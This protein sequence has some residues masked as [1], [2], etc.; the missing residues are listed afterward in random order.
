MRSLASW[1]VLGVLG[2]SSCGGNSSSSEGSNGGSNGNDEGTALCREGCEAVL[3]A[4]CENGPATQDS[5]ESDC[6]RLARGGCAEQYQELQG[7]SEGQSVTC[8]GAGIPVVPDCAAEQNAF[9][10]CLN[11]AQ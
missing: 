8:N 5:C 1:L 6:R 7:C 10:A 2:L 11:P 9:I 3:A 4:A